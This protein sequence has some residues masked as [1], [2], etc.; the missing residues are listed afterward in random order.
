MHVLFGIHGQSNI[1]I[2]SIQCHDLKSFLTGATVTLLFYIYQM[3][4]VMATASQN[5]NVVLGI[6][7]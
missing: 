1:A 7:Y 2:E 4:L 5:S 6:T 3:P